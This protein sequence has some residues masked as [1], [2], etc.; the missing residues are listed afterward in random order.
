M[1]VV[2]GI[3]SAIGVDIVSIRVGTMT[4][5]VVGIL[6]G[7]GVG[8]IWV[9]VGPVWGGGVVDVAVGVGMI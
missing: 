8:T 9:G 1:V 3:V 7:V 5:G 2:V 6:R 4:I